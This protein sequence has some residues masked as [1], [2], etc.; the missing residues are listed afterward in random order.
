MKGKIIVV[1]TAIS[2]FAIITQYI[3]MLQNRVASVGETTIRFF[4]F[5]TI[6]TNLLIAFY[7]ASLLFK[8][9]SLRLFFNRSG[10]LTALTTYITIVCLV[11]QLVLRQM[12]TP[13]GMQR[14]V[15]ELL[16]SVIPVLVV[17]FWYYYENKQALKYSMIPK[18]LCYPGIYLIYIL[19]R[20]QFSGFYPYPFMNV[21]NLGMEKV[22][23]NSALLMLV[24]IFFCFLF[25]VVG[26][27]TVTRVENEN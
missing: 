15:D 9:S 5:F 11:Y 1:F 16:H 14:I 25:I 21:L 7:F 8:N 23:I 13:T 20:G 22:L 12:W 26:R 4:S 6:L 19:M 17:F 18:W 2:W 10:V 24:F 27:A 3:L